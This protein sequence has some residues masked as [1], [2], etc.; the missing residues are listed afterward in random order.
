MNLNA[1]FLLCLPLLSA[2]EPTVTGRVV[3]D[4]KRPETKLLPGTPEQTKGCCPDGKSVDLADPRL[5]IDEKGGLANVVVTVEVEGQKAE[6]S[7]DPLV[8]DQKACIFDPHVAV[9]HAGGTVRFLNSDKVTHNV[10]AFSMRNEAFN[11]VMAPGGKDDI[12][13]EKPDKVTI[14]CDYHPWMSMVI[15]VT[16]TPFHAVTK[17]DGT[18][19]IAGLK[20][21]T[22]KVKLW[23][24]LLGRAEAEVVIQPDG[25]SAPLEVRMAEKKKKQ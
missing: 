11:N 7:K 15:F 2:A 20:P 24:E 3:F 5:L 19:S 16:D 9:L 21:G 17:P 6:P 4:G 18:F 22:H 23:H 14:T 13:L 12:V 10:R 25:S 8:I 1:L